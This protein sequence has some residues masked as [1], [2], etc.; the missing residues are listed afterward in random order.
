MRILLSL[1]FSIFASTA[2]ASGGSEVFFLLWITQAFT[3]FWPLVLPLFFLAET[4]RKGLVFLAGLFCTHGALG[5]AGIP[6][7]WYTQLMMWSNSS[8]GFNAHSIFL[9]LVA[10][11][12]VAVFIAILALR[13]VRQHFSKNELHGS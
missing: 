9:P 2:F 1:I 7:N 11:H 5:L 13:K 8:P 12:I 3:L 10:Q 6:W 4:P